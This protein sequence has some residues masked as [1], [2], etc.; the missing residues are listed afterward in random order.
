MKFGKLVI[1]IHK[2]Y[3]RYLLKIALKRHFLFLWLF[4]LVLS[5]ALVRHVRRKRRCEPVRV[6][7]MQNR[8]LHWRSNLV[9]SSQILCA[10]FHCSVIILPLFS[11]KFGLMLMY[12]LCYLYDYLHMWPGPRYLQMYPPTVLTC[13][14]ELDRGRYILNLIDSLFAKW[15]KSITIILFLFIAKWLYHHHS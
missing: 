2:V 7:F 10:D 8:S 1:W 13:T 11:M 12:F 3:F 4:L 14:T 6:V 15:L 9:F 5:W